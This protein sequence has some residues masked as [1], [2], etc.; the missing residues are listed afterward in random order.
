MRSRAKVKRNAPPDD[1]RPRSLRTK[2]GVPAPLTF[3]DPDTNANYRFPSR[4][5]NAGI[6]MKLCAELMKKRSLAS[7]CK[8]PGMPSTATVC[9]WLANPKFEEFQREYY[10][11]RRVAAE[12][13]IDEIFEIADDT[14]HDWKPTFNKAGDIKGWK[15]DNE[16]IQRSRVKIDIRKWY[17]SKMIPRMYGENMDITHGVTG[18]LAEL[19]KAA[20]N[21]D[22]GLPNKR[23]EKI[24]NE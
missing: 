2:K 10:K 21:K 24:I 20:S 1:K 5:Y 18:D 7:V 14:E 23:R 13:Y 11:A 15:P 22:A 6:A 9:A 12:L 8:D 16:A 19:L 4:K 17:A 3:Y